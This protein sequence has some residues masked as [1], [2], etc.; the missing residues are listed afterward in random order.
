METQT[1]LAIHRLN[2]WSDFDIYLNVPDRSE[3]WKY[4]DHVYREL[5][6]LRPLESID[7][8]KQVH[9]D[10]RD[11]F[12][13]ICCMFIREDHP[14]YYFTPD[15]KT[16]KRNELEQTPRANSRNA[17]SKKNTGGNRK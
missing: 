17:Q 7:V 6:K 8:L 1:N 5:I 12:I 16:L 10:S 3:F 4:V 13:K 15:Y 9:P 2:A 14:D 11:K